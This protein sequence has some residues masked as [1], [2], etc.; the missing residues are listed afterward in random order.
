MMKNP[1]KKHRHEQT[2][3]FY[4][5]L[6]TVKTL[7]FMKSYL[8]MIVI[9]FITLQSSLAQT[10]TGFG[11][12]IP[13]NQQPIIFPLYAAGL[14]NA[15]LDS[16]FGVESV[17][18]DITHTYDADLQ[19]WLI[20]P[21]NTY[22]E[23][24]SG[25]GVGDDNYTATCFSD[26]STALIST[27]AA[28]FTGSFKPESPLYIANNGVNPNNMWLLYIVDTYPQ[29]AGVLNSW[30][31]TFGPNVG[32]P[33][34]FPSSNLPIIKINTLGQSIPDDPKITARMQIIDN[35][36][37]NRNYVNDSVYTY[38]GYIGIEVRGSSSQMFPKKSFS[39]ETRD[40]LGANLDISIL[41]M[42]AENDWIL[43][44]NYTDKTFLRNVMTY[45][46]A[47]QMGHYASRTRYAEVFINGIY[48]GLYVFMEKIKRDANRVNISSLALN[49]TTGT[50]VT[51]G[52][53]LKIDKT[54]GSGTGGFNSAF[55][56]YSGGAT[57]YILYDYPEDIA[58]APQQ[59]NYIQAFVDSFESALH[60][61]QFTNPLI[62]YAKYIND[63]SFID[64]FL[65]NELSKN[66]DG[67]R[68]S[69]Y[70]YKE[71][72]TK[73]NRLVAGP[74]WDY[75]IAWGNADYYNGQ[76]TT[77]WSYQFNNTGDGYQVPFWW[78]KLLSDQAFAN[79]L[80]CRYDQMR[81]TFL[82]TSNMNNY[83]DSV[84]SYLQESQDR[85]FQVWPILGAYVW[86]NPSPIPSSYAGEI[87]NIKAWISSRLL[88]LDTYMPG[89]CTVS[90]INQLIAANGISAYPNPT[91]DR[92]TVSSG[93]GAIQSATVLNL[94]GKTIRDFKE[95]NAV[96]FEINTSTLST[97]IYLLKV[98]S[99]EGVSMLKFSKL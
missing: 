53:I 14:T 30:S 51:G 80:Q 90:S 45:H 41:G 47:E 89:T 38:D 19:I 58:I 96:E 7:L 99:N 95:I 23:L 11:G 73:G 5:Y 79:K 36:A 63:T 57:P 92:L 2:V 69:S 81:S 32:Q 29:D 43:N 56:P 24:S 15:S 35:G 71:K 25:N 66:V 64:F 40:S 55:P 68:I 93:Y 34:M 16:S 37:G 52:Y 26:L 78:A 18:I 22:I 31:I 76:Y 72:S 39:V 97:G 75:D 50:A 3:L 84:S 74:V 98:I 70:F 65:A 94:S 33:F 20:T 6:C 83:I 61:N 17:C 1:I 85:N 46:L 59:V 62:G 54:T 10:F 9:C 28:P 87:N 21:D 67:Y 42:P 4:L 77:G 91:S 44:A 12:A 13:D 86:P 49:D 88:W 48:Q 8:L 27:S 82:S 60:G